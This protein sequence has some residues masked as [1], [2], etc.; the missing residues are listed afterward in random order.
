MQDSGIDL[1]IMPGYHHTAFKIE[2]SSR[3]S[4]GSYYQFMANL[5]NIPAG[6]VTVGKV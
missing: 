3:F 4:A 2:N 6:V 5:L 1:I